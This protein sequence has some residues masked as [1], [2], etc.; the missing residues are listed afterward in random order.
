MALPAA[1][2]TAAPTDGCI[3]SRAAKA[4]GRMRTCTRSRRPPHLPS[5][6]HARSAPAPAAPPAVSGPCAFSHRAGAHVVY[7][8][9]DDHL[10]A[11]SRLRGRWEHTDLIAA[12]GVSGAA[13][14]AGDPV[15]AS[16]GGSARVFYV[17]KDSAL[18]A[19]ALGGGRRP[20]HGGGGPP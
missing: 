6:G 17:G 20:E 14:A 1:S 19:L 7:R 12:A 16:A 11:L 13:C 4:A 2:H 9:A 5:R 3:S 18:H 8:A 10:H 15:G